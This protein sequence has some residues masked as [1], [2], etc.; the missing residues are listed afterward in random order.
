MAIFLSMYTKTIIRLGFCVTQINQGHGKGYQP[1][2][3]ASADNPYL[4]FDCSG[5]QKPQSNNCLLQVWNI[6]DTTGL[7]TDNINSFLKLFDN[8]RIDCQL[9]VPSLCFA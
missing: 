6:C 9:Q 3:L 8:V 7:V 5:N 2:S 1:Q 4:D